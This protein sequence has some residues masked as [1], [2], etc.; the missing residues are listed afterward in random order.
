ME[1][2]EGARSF[3]TTGDAYDAFMGR[4]SRELSGRFVDATGVVAGNRA[5]DVGCGPG[6]LTGA[7]VD[8][9]GAGGVSAVDPSPP[10]VAT[11]ELRHPGV[12]VRL[13]R[14]E[15]LPF[16]DAEFDV[17]LAQLVLHFV[18]DPELAARE[19]RR[20][21][22]PGGIVAA[23]MWD[24]ADGME[25]LRHFWDAALSVDPTAPDELRALRFGRQ[26]EI[27]GL[28]EAAGLDDIEET[29]LTVHS[30]Y[31]D[32]EELWSGFLAGIG[33]AGTFCV[34]LS[35]EQRAA[36]RAELFA[37]VG[38]PDGSFGLAAMARSARARVPG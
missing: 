14:A 27:A 2:A 32:F 34:S 6:A 38:S 33:P 19:L 17:A 9:V 11:C 20:V 37:R 8:R 26:G 22:R 10:F 5:L 30:T 15:D 36:V 4:Y 35:D 16:G 24:F 1:P 12:R 25:M 3:L 7:L 29:M 18:T 31:A 13:G 28:F 23:C 21:V